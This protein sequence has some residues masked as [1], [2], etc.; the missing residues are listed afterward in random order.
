MREHHLI[1][2]AFFVASQLCSVAAYAQSDQPDLSLSRL[3]MLAGDEALLGSERTAV[4]GDVMFGTGLAIADVAL[5]DRTMIVRV[6]GLTTVASATEPLREATIDEPRFYGLSD[7][8][9]TYCGPLQRLNDEARRGSVDDQAQQRRGRP[10]VIF[11]SAVRFCYIDDQRDGSF[12]RAFID[13]ARTAENA[14]PIGIE[15]AAYRHVPLFELGGVYLRF[16]YLPG[17]NLS[18]PLIDLFTNMHQGT[19]LSPTIT[20]RNDNGRTVGLSSRRRPGGGNF[21]KQ[22]EFGDV[23]IT[24]LGEDAATNRITY[25]VDRTFRQRAI[26]L[27]V[28][29]YGLYGAGTTFTYE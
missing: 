11:D 2:A 21:P 1:A 16:E 17:A 28:A 3:Q 23:Q 12:D 25:R 13:G 20:F 29:F 19:R 8:A 18:P 4:P 26:D 15:P 14:Q 27:E 7:S 6:H 22:L 24:V 5:P 9:R 10:R